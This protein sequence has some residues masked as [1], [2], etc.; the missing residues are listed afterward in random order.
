MKITLKEL[1]KIVREENE[2]L[3]EKMSS[4]SRKGFHR[5]GHT[6]KGYRRDSTW[7]DS[8]EVDP[9]DIEASE[10]EYDPELRS[11]LAKKHLVKRKYE[12][13]S[14]EDDLYENKKKDEKDL[15]LQDD[16]EEDLLEDFLFEKEYKAIPGMKKYLEKGKFNN[17]KCISDLSDKENIKNPAA[18][19]RAAEIVLTGE[20]EPTRKGKWSEKQHRKQQALLPGG[21]TG[22]QKEV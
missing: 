11:K 12:S 19:C 9:S 1:R 4:Y 22:R 8:A 10:V 6:R 5:K 16:D 3:K 21:K 13:L 15:L 18:V 14:E 2:L 7:V 20:A 17:S